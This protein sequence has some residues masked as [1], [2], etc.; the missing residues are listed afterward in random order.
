MNPLIGRN[1]PDVNKAVEMKARLLK[2][3]CIIFWLITDFLDFYH[4]A[5]KT[6]FGF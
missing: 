1:K 3:F 5:E 2:G 4:L 6:Q